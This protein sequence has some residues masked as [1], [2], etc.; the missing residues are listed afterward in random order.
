VVELPTIA[1][2]YSVNINGS[3]DGLLL[4]V[5]I[6]VNN[7]NWVVIEP[8]WDYDIPNIWKII[9]FMFQTTSQKR[10]NIN[11]E[12]P[13]NHQ[14]HWEYSKKFIG[15]KN[16]GAERTRQQGNRHGCYLNKQYIC[17]KPNRVRPGKKIMPRA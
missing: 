7:Y 10:I 8:S 11:N 2:L 1:W 6:M 4:M 17:N 16:F 12:N 9:K 3:Y 14:W 13:N 5:I 15:K